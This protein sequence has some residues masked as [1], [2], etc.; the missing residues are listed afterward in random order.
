MD[1]AGSKQECSFNTTDVI[2]HLVSPIL[3]NSSQESALSQLLLQ[4]LTV[5][6]HNTSAITT[7]CSLLRRVVCSLSSG[8]Q[9]VV[10]PVI[11]SLL[12]STMSSSQASSTSSRSDT[13]SAV[14]VSLLT[15]L[16]AYVRVR[17][18]ADNS[19]STMLDIMHKTLTVAVSLLESSALRADSGSSNDIAAMEVESTSE[20]QLT[21]CWQLIAVIVNKVRIMKFV[22]IFCIFFHFLCRGT[23]LFPQIPNSS[24]LSDVLQKIFSLLSSTIS[25]SIASSSGSPDSIAQQRTMIMLAR[26]VDAFTW[27][28]K[29]LLLRP[30]M[31]IIAGTSN[32][33]PAE[34]AG[35]WQK[36]VV[37]QMRGFLVDPLP[38]SIKQDSAEHGPSTGK[39]KRR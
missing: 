10:V 8:Q 31:K 14:A 5:N 17:A 7:I 1:V 39:R 27:T 6:T 30:D 21:P 18:V 32:A 29:S 36:Y 33:P 20:E 15:S 19:T 28:A 38:Q 35:S 24:E 11:A 23:V 22:L 16:F 4:G 37:E 2:N 25:S 34:G 9:V 13:G 3:T 26:A 12:L